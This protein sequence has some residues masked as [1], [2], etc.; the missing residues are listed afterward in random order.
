MN[1]EDVS[2]IEVHMIWCSY[3]ESNRVLL[4]TKQVPHQLALGAFVYLCSGRLTAFRLMKSRQPNFCDW[5]ETLRLQ[6]SQRFVRQ[7]YQPLRGPSLL[8]H[9]S[10]VRAP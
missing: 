2:I 8:I 10:P 1:L 3:T 9:Y 6:V 7:D 5:V 4:I